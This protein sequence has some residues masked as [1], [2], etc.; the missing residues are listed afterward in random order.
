MLK[1][2]YDKTDQRDSTFNKLETVAQVY[3]FELVLMQN[4]IFGKNS[5]IPSFIKTNQKD[6]QKVQADVT[7]LVENFDIIQRSAF[8]THFLY[9]V[10][11]FMHR[12]STELKL[13][14]QSEKFMDVTKEVLKSLFP[15]DWESKRDIIEL[16][17]ECRNCLHNDGIYRHNDKTITVNGTCYKFEKNKEPQFIGW[18][19]L[20]E[21]CNSIIDVL[22]EIRNI[23]ITKYPHIERAEDV[24]K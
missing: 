15:T 20:Y 11:V 16:P 1:D 19:N 22:E 5:I 18:P 8:L 23:T 12:L 14:P 17:T 3:F 7:I 24:V 6:L 13:S 2:G 9:K 4:H 21:Q 10:E